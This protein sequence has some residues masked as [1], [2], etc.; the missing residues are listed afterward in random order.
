M[1]VSLYIVS[2]DES[3]QSDIF[4]N[5]KALAGVIV[6]T[7]LEALAKDNDLDPLNDYIRQTQDQIEEF[8]VNELGLSENEFPKLPKQ[9]WYPPEKGLR[10]IQ[11]HKELVK[12]KAMWI[13]RDRVPDI[14]EDL[15]EFENAFTKLVE[16]NVNW[17]F[18]LDF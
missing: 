18:A 5:G 13:G 2:E 4:V 16:H 15:N 8:F 17:Y 14:L 11:E 9:N 1:G 12:Q 7:K 3:L 6:D 10:L